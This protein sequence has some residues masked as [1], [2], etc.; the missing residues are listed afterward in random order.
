MGQRGRICMCLCGWAG[1]S[2]AGTDC[3]NS[4]S[5]PANSATHPASQPASQTASQGTAQHGKSKEQPCIHPAIVHI[6]SPRLST[7]TVCMQR[8]DGLRPWR[9]GARS[10]ISFRRNKKAKGHERRWK[11]R[12]RQRL[13]GVGYSQ[14]RRSPKSSMHGTIPS[15]WCCCCCCCSASTNHNH[16]C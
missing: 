5:E 9:R 14:A 16:I 1:R 6:A 10:S 13:D 7:S 4:A 11:G 8:R 2:G 3:C 15:F 12:E